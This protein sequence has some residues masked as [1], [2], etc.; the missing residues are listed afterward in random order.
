MANELVHEKSPY[1]LMHSNDPID[2]MPWSERAFSKAAAENRLIFLSIGYSTCHWC[3]VIHDESFSDKDVADILNKNYVCIKVDR[4]ERPDLDSYFMNVS[5]VINGSGG[6]P[7]NVILLPDR[8]PVFAFT[9][10]PKEDRR[11]M[12]GLKTLAQQIALIWKNDPQQFESQAVAV[13]D[14]VKNRMPGRAK[15]NVDVF[16]KLEL[17]LRTSFDLQD[18]GFSG[19]PKFF[20]TPALNYLLERFYET[21]NEEILNFIGLT[22]KTISI[23]GI[24]DL[25]NGGFFRY[26][27]D[28]MWIVPHFEKMLYTQTQL[29]KLFSKMFMLTRDNVYRDMIY[30]IKRF[31]D[32]NLYWPG[33]GYYSGMDAD[34]DG[35]EGGYYKWSFQDLKVA[36][37]Q[38]FEAFRAIFDIS[39]GGNYMDELYGQ[40]GDN[41]IYFTGSFDEYR[42]SIE[43]NGSTDMLSRSIEKLREAEKKRKKP[44]VDKKILTDLNGLAISSLSWAYR[45]TGDK[46]FLDSAVSVSEFIIKNM[47]G[48]YL[49]HSFFEGSAS[50]KSSL[51]D[52]A[53]LIRGLIDLYTITFDQKYLEEAKKLADE[54]IK[55]LFDGKFKLSEEIDDPQIA[56]SEVES[57]YATIVA[58]L[59]DLSLLT[60]DLQYHQIADQALTSVFDAVSRFPSAFPSMVISAEKH[61]YGKVVSCRANK[62]REA[63]S[64]IPSEIALFSQLE[65]EKYNICT[66]FACLN[67][68]ESIDVLKRSIYKL[69]D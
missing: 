17:S 57:P 69:A 9:Y 33:H 46:E 41:L 5:A 24:H 37:G 61:I 20:N 34:V 10:V 54:A 64:I 30:D 45:A 16:S 26:S 8:R 48:D 50:V 59:D 44:S 55:F 43:E 29:M 68:V 49:L 11:G 32:E 60:E 40:T 47:I 66:Y 28:T 31:M 19:S 67:P 58:D 35:N 22:L 53:F 12:T 14:A 18:G 21:G 36:L 6:W 62:V 23:R 65:S 52:Y 27:T 7:L 38:D 56:D 39:E 15:I 13:M 4:E 63:E 42:R 25:V 2:W 3:H 1:L 51:F